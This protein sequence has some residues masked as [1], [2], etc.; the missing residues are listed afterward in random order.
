M[1][2]SHGSFGLVI[3]FH[4]PKILE[5][6]VNNIMK[7][8]I[9]KIIAIGIGISIM[10]GN[11]VQGFA[12]EN[13]EKNIVQ[14]SIDAT[15]SSGSITKEVITNE[16]N[17]IINGQ[18]VNSKAILTLEN[19]IKSAID[20]SDK[21]TLKSK[22][23]TMYRNK[24]D[25]Q[26]KNNDFYES[27]NQKVYDFP[28]DK[29]E[30]QE[31]QTKQSQEFLEDQISNDITGKYNAIIMKEIDIKKAKTNL[32]IKNK[33]LDTARTKVRIGMAT[34]NQ[35]NDKQIE[36]KSLQDDMK[37]KEDSLKNNVDY[38]GILI[39][40]NLSNYS[41]DQS[42]QY[43]IFKIDGSVDGYFDDKIDT[44]LKYNNEMIKLTK[45]YLD[46]L[47]DDGI[48]N[49]VDSDIP[50]IPDKAK[51]AGIDQNT[52]TA[53]F[54]SSGYALS[55]IDYMQKQQIFLKKLDAYGSYLDG[56]YSLDES[57]IKLEDAKKSLKNGLKEGYSTL[58][59]LENKINSL[60]EQI[61]ST[62]T[63]LRYAKSQVDIGMMT[64]NT[65]KAQVLKSEDLDTALRNLINTYN[66]LANNIQ[67]PWILSS[68]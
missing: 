54:N 63:K 21:L 50:Q 22:E 52:G 11:M 41:L 36:V 17:S 31:K 47:K 10:N 40:L 24:M 39:G 19:V 38:L 25:I 13:N 20:N 60:K 58:L 28:Y 32:E 33:E 43:D 18:V 45:D 49:I 6:R 9:K 23:I 5:K 66:T 8:N 61:K 64:E 29:L 37:A 56:R 57:R 4:V 42:I 34:D 62:N 30:L 55:L 65:Y 2:N 44:Y 7:K 67:K 53:T 12:A 26:D 16:S 35:L 27:I 46:E 3:S 59:D 68:K 48:K 15:K 1:K 51:F 14:T